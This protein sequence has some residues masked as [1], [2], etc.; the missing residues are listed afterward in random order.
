MEP[1]ELLNFFAPNLDMPEEQKISALAIAESR[2]PW[3]LS[4]AQQNEA[5]ALY[6]AWLLTLQA[7]SNFT[8]VRELGVTSEREGDLSKTY[9]DVT[10]SLDAAGFKARYDA[11]A[12]RCTVK[13]HR[14]ACAR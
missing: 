9:G 4:E 14:G 1:L 10:D 2:R 12:R 5:Q 13:L 11:Y 7:Q 8:D 6:A 3:C